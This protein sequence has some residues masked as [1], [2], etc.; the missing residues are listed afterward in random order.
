MRPFMAS[1]LIAPVIASQI[2]GLFL[3][4]YLKHDT[5]LMASIQYALFQIAVSCFLLT[6]F[7]FACE[8]A[9]ASGYAGKVKEKKFPKKKTF[10]SRKSKVK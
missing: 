5:S 6:I 10:T 3:E 4:H 9:E 2:E 7:V 8:M 1:V